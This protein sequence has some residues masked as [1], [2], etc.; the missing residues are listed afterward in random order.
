MKDKSD[1]TGKKILLAELERIEHANQHHY[2][3]QINETADEKKRQVTRTGTDAAKQH[4]ELYDIEWTRIQNWKKRTEQ[5][6]MA[7]YKKKE[8]EYRKNRRVKYDEIESMMNDSLM[9]IERTRELNLGR[10][11]SEFSDRKEMIDRAKK[12]LE[13]GE[14]IEIKRV[15]GEIIL[16]IPDATS[17]PESSLQPSP[18]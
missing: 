3:K 18:A 6:L 16:H 10:V 1:N 14:E 17:S 15:E 13:D 9:E 5:K 7:L 12:M 2:T 4:G 11:N 8:A